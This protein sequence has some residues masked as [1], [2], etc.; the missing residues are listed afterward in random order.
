MLFL[1][2][3]INKVL[4]IGVEPD[5]IIFANPAKPVSHI[6]HAA[7]VGI[8]IM[9]FDNESELHKVLQ[10]Y[11]HARLVIRIRCD[12]PD[13]QCQLGMKFG[14]NHDTEAPGLL[15]LAK[16]LGLDVIGVSFHVGSGCNNP[17]IFHTAINYARQ[18]HKKNIQLLVCYI[19]SDD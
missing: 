17:P 6:R 8:D 1:Q 19:I 11:P 5:R 7:N 15:H 18:V 14:C 10:L 2:G 12:D 13:A 3:E 9:T 16:D 4:D